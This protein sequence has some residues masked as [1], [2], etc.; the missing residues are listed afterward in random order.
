LAET[1]RRL[2]GE[3]YEHNEIGYGLA[4][5][6]NELLTA[7]DE[8]PEYKKDLDA[9]R[10]CMQRRGFTEDRPQAAANRLASEY[11]MGKLSLDEL[12]TLEVTV[13]TA[14]TECFVATDLASSREAA[15]A[16]AE[17]QLLARNTEKLLAMQ[18]ARDEALARAET[19]LGSADL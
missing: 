15:E 19:I 5:L 6:H 18:H 8:D 9:W 10:D 1:R 17:E 3:D 13:A 11:H 2:Y 4:F 14:D 7:A 16:R 12:R